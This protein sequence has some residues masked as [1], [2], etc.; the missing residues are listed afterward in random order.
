[1]NLPRSIE[2]RVAQRTVMLVLAGYI[3]RVTC[4]QNG[5]PHCAR[6]F[7]ILAAFAPDKAVTG[8]CSYLDGCLALTDHFAD[9]TT[10]RLPKTNASNYRSLLLLVALALYTDMTRIF[11]L[12][13]ADFEDS[14]ITQC[15][16]QIG[17]DNC[18]THSAID[19]PSGCEPGGATWQ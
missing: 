14:H 4:L 3:R 8:R 16:A 18:G 10:E 1:M 15:Y 13:P 19:R 5:S 11:T 12:F 2:G 6:S 17:A 9:R 7:W